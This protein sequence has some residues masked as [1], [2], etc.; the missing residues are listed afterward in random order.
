MGGVEG[1]RVWS[2]PPLADLCQNADATFFVR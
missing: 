1:D 2:P